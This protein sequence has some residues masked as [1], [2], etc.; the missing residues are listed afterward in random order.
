MEPRAAAPPAPA[1]PRSRRR[2]RT[3]H[4]IPASTSIMAAT[5]ASTSA[6]PRSGCA[7]DQNDKQQRNQRSGHQ[8]A[9][10]VVHGVEP[11]MQKPRQKQHQHG[12][13][14]LRRLESE[15]V[16]EANPAMR[17]VRAGHQK[18]Q[19]QQHRG[20]AQGGIDETRRVVVA[21]VHVHQHKQSQ[22]SRHG[23]DGLREHE[24]VGRVIALLIDH[25]GGGE[26]HRPARRPPAPAW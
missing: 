1:E 24:R 4:S 2:S 18:H 8:R 23:P 15:E 6:V 14:D 10:P 17:V 12:L 5:P 26:D 13:G 11:L 16:A 21:D 3:F 25:G 9:F 19:H 22:H 20:D 7:S